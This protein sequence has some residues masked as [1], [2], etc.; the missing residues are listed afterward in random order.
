VHQSGAEALE[1]LALTQ[2]DRCLVAGAPGHVAGALRALSRRGVLDQSD[3][4]PD[5]HGEQGAGRDQG[6]GEG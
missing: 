2:H 1:Q 6:S 5:P 4:P 3:K